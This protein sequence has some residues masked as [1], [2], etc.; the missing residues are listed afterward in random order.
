MTK[1]T[2]TVSH[3]GGRLLGASVLAATG[4]GALWLGTAHLLDLLRGLGQ[5]TGRGIDAAT[6]A[7]LVGLGLVLLAWYVLSGTITALCLAMRLTGLVWSGGERLVRRAGAPAVRR[8]LGGGAGAVLVAGAL[9][10]PAHAVDGDD[11]ASNPVHLTWTPTQD[12]GPVE[13]EDDDESST[14]DD[15]YGTHGGA[16]PDQ[17]EPPEQDDRTEQ[18]V[19]SGVDDPPGPVYVVQPGDT[20][21]SVA[22]HSLGEQAEPAEVADWWPR[23]YRTNLDVIGDDPDLIHPGQELTHPEGRAS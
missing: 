5:G 11:V 17:Q 18:D 21:W 23:W 10:G 16:E 1:W 14:P 22:A 15:G 12:P 6:A 13:G 3:T 2:T 20:L 4:S 8:L 7:V 19:A 9:L